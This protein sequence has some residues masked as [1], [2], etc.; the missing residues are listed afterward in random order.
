MMAMK[1]R[2]MSSFK[3][4]VSDHKINMKDIELKP[5]EFGCALQAWLS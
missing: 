1:K 5:S 4:A 2:E 3:R